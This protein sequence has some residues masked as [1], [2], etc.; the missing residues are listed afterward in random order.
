MHLPADIHWTPLAEAEAR[1]IHRYIAVDSVAAA[2]RQLDLVLESIQGLSM[3]P[4]KGR[5]GR[6]HDTRELVVP[7]T[8]YIVVYRLK[9]TG[10]QIL[11]I[12]HGAR[13]WP[14]RFSEE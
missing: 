12:L 5:T 7:A 4:G 2:N 10:I 8:P 11:S 9:L 13:R 6:V 14:S 1:E 3:L